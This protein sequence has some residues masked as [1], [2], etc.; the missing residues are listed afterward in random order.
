MRVLEF[1]EQKTG[2]TIFAPAD[3]VVAF[4]KRGT[5][6]ELLLQYGQGLGYLVT[7]QPEEIAKMVDPTRK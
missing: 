2:D 6:S 3:K 5:G 4:R 7:A 1:E